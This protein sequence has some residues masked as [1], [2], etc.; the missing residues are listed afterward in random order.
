MGGN[1][2][3]GNIWLLQMWGEPLPAAS[4]ANLYFAQLSGVPW[5]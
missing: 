4:V 2:Y 5:P 1:F 3:D